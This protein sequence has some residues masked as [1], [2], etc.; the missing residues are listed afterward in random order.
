MLKFIIRTLVFVPCLFLSSVLSAQTE[1]SE[2]YS[3]SGTII[4]FEDKQPLTGVTILIKGT[5]NY[6]F[7]GLDGSFRFNNLPVGTYALEYTYIGHDNFEETIILNENKSL[8]VIMTEVSQMIEGVVVTSY[9]DYSSDAS[10]RTDERKANHVVNILSARS[11]ELSPDMTVA[12][13]TQR[14]SGVSLERNNNG[15]GQYAIVRGMDKR[16]NYTLVNGIKIPSPD[17]KNRYVPLDIFPSDLLDRLV[18]S[19]SLLPDME[20]DAIGGVIDMRM[21]DAPANFSVNLN[22]GLGYNMLNRQRPFRV[23][24]RS[25]VNR[26]SPNKANGEGYLATLND[27]PA[28][29]L[30]FS[31]IENP[32]NKFYSFSV[33]NRFFKNKLG[34]IIAASHQNTFRGA[35]SMFMSTFVDQENNNPYYEIMQQR[36]FSTEQKRTG[37]HSKLDFRPNAANKISLYLAYMDLQELEVRSRIDTILKIGRGQGPGTGR[38]ELRERSRQRLQKIFNGTLQGDH[39]L[40][41]KF[42]IDWSLVYSFAKNDDPDM[43]E[44]KWLTGVVRNA[45]GELIKEPI[46]YDRDFSRRWTNNSDTDLAAYLNSSYIKNVLGTDVN[47][48]FGGLFRNKLRN[49]TFDSYLFRTAP[50]RQEWTGDVKDYT[51]TLFNSIGTP[52]DPLNYECTENVAAAYAMFRFQINNTQFIGGVRNET[53]WFSWITNSP[54]QLQGRVGDI[55]YNDFLPSLHVKY[56]P[57]TRTNIRA[58]Y[59]SSLSRPNFFEVIPYDIFEEDFRERGNPNLNRTTA[60]NLD[61]RYEYF[62]S[63]VDQFLVG[64]FYKRIQDP[65]ES[66]LLIQGQTIFLQPNN[67]GTANNMGVEIDITKYFKQLGIRAFYTFT[68]SQ[69]TTTKIVRFRDEQGNLTSRNVDQTRPLQGQSRHI[70][71]VALLYKS[72]KSGLDMQIAMVYTG[73]RIISVSPYLDNDI[74]QRGFVQ[75]DFSIDKRLYKGL[76]LYAKVNN[77]LNTPLLADIRLPN[78]FNPEQAPYLDSSKNVLVREDFYWQTILLGIKYKF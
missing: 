1:T 14:V 10:A 69:I 73:D 55:Q 20:G 30:N 11:I 60:N 67:F 13:I 72:I 12:N 78:T 33:G 21:K 37:M 26:L 40:T 39:T 25:Q 6:T 48:S 56:M 52:T 28:N 16:Y 76:V 15:D 59:F 66:A 9:K 2:K 77:I 43:A 34:W 19:K 53:T 18:V 32:I 54:P 5:N 3:L 8:N 47:F 45:A 41:R 57:N 17:A 58:S 49:N 27:F 75:L 31:D 63:S 61:L 36:E 38:V 7:S 35:N 46:L 44:L 4:S 62:H 65:I 51:F 23:F 29:N 68:S 64:L 24:D 50:I 22:T 71:N 42:S 74:W 70:S